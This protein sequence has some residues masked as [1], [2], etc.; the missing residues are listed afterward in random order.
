MNKVIILYIIL[1][2]LLFTIINKSLNKH[3]NFIN[4]YEIINNGFGKNKMKENSNDICVSK[5]FKNFRDL[6][7]KNIYLSFNEK[8][9]YF[10]FFMFNYEHK[11]FMKV[12]V[13]KNKKNFDIKDD[14]NNQIGGLVKR[15]HNRYVIDLKKMYKYDYFFIIKSNYQEIKIYNDF[16][17]NYYYLKKMNDNEKHK[18]K[19]YLFEE[20]IG[21]INNDSHNFK[22]FIKDKYLD[23]INLFSYALILFIIHNKQ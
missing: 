21:H 4:I 13:N 14:E 6:F 10:E 3:E 17:Y 1:L 8:S 22:F 16:E 19:L 23:K 7:L 12:T 2:L 15:M 5:K 9:T 20:E 11:L 18:Y